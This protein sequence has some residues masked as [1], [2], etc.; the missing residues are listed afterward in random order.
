MK[1][2]ALKPDIIMMDSY[3][4][5]EFL[6]CFLTESAGILSVSA[7][8]IVNRNKGVIPLTSLFSW[9]KPLL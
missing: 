8:K 5:E 3:L 4:S 6:L 9:K 2:K 1:S 7:K